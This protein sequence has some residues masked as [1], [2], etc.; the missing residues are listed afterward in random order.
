MPEDYSLRTYDCTTGDGDVEQLVDSS[1]RRADSCACR[2]ELDGHDGR[3][4]DVGKC[5]QH[6]PSVEESASNDCCGLW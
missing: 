2:E 3:N 5:S 1:I 4:G 6:E